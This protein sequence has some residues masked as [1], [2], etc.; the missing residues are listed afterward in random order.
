M[1]M[2][3]PKMEPKSTGLILINIW[4]TL[5]S[6]YLS[7]KRLFQLIAFLLLLILCAAADV[8]SIGLAL[9]FLLLLTNA[10]ALASNSRLK[11]IL[12]MLPL[13]NCE[14]IIIVSVLF[15]SAALI[16]ALIRISSIYLS[17]RLA[18]GI[19]S[20]LSCKA[21]SCALCQPYEYHMLKNS[22]EIITTITT[23]VNRSIVG[24]N[25]LLQ[26]IA[27]SLVAV[28][29]ICGLII[30]NPIVATFAALFLGTCYYL[31]AG[32][33]RRG[34]Q[35][36]SAII[37]DA[38]NRQLKSLHEG[39]GAIRNVIID[40]LQTA[41][42]DIY[43][44]TDIVQRKLQAKN[45]FISSFPRPLFEGTSIALISLVGA[46]SSL[47]HGS[48][49]Q[50][51][52]TLGLYALGAQRLLPALQ[53]CYGCWTILN[54]TKSD[55]GG[56]LELLDE[57]STIP[58]TRIKS[59]EVPKYIVFT[60]VSFR[61]KNTS[62]AVLDNLNTR[63]RLGESIGV[64]GASGSGKS[65]LLDLL[66]GLLSPTSGHITA[67]YHDG[68]FLA[69][70]EESESWQSLIS[71]VPQDIYLSD[72][73]FAEN[74]AFGCPIDSI[75]MNRVCY[76]ANCA[77]IST[78]IESTDSGYHTYVGERGTQLS[79]GQ[80]QRIGIA[81]AIYKNCPIL[82]LDEATSSLDPRLEY[83]VMNKLR[84]FKSSLTTFITAHRLSTLEN[85]DR[86]IRLGD[87]RIIADGKP[88]N[89]LYSW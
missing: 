67:E 41:Y 34:L 64:V 3:T 86:I 17:G 9:P 77:C 47:I 53:H 40:R 25:H 22:S 52:P 80:K 18:A 43:K 33:T 6:H 75:D 62:N 48:S 29:I 70:S 45:E 65:T 85:C 74:I 31:V 58:N 28:F 4:V 71:H 5:I 49:N 12:G 68:T 66:M 2:P 81:R 10:D 37:S 76:A 73:T 19:G 42:V 55:A 78:Y 46:Q 7:K 1:Y 32:F 13:S 84:S 11:H 87:G 20:D 44:K 30:V 16:A 69:I 57:R 35:R 61:Y 14:P 88:E 23:K 15:A 50:I 63:M 83:E 79:G 60:S 51:I 27:S 82:F 72:S 24:L 38:T 36:N 56:L 54:A 21:F 39:L 8:I 26:L 59:I 89:V